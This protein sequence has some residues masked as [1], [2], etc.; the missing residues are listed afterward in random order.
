M[1]WDNMP[2]VGNSKKYH[3]STSPRKEPSNERNFKIH[4]SKKPQYIHAFQVFSLGV[5]PGPNDRGSTAK[6]GADRASIWL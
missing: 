3:H 1:C 4:K 6:P 2:S 5:V